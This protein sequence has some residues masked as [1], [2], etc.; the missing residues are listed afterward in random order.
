MSL[1]ESLR[2]SAKF[3]L[4]FWIIEIADWILPMDLDRYG[5][6]P[7]TFD[8]LIGIL[9]APFLHGGFGHLLSNTPT[10]LVLM[11]GML[12]FYPRIA[13]RGL[14]F[15]YLF[16]GLAV[17]ICA[18]DSYHIGAS[19][20]MYGLASFLFFSGLFRREAAALAIALGV[21]ILYG[22]MVYGILP[23]YPGVSWESHL[24]G[25][26]VGGWTAWIFRRDAKDDHQQQSPDRYDDT[27]YVEGYRNIENKRVRYF[28]R[29]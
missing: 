4:A 28:Y 18:R 14:L 10:F 2:T 11:T 24:A 1:T 7:R 25:A 16:T 5:I 29:S 19:G 6:Y 17:W 9:F 13:V 23:Q 15:I 3:V 27:D 26:V 21:A 22:G 20:V 12:F 8:G